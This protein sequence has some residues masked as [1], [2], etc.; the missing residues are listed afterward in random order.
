M[1][2]KIDDKVRIK[3]GIGKGLIGRITHTNI[4]ELAYFID[5]IAELN[6]WRAENSLELA[7]RKIEDGLEEGDIIVSEY[8]DSC[9]VLGVC[10]K[11]IFLSKDFDYDEAEDH[12]Y[13]LKW[14]IGQGYTLKDQEKETVKEEFIKISKKDIEGDF[15]LNKEEAL[16]W[17][18][19]GK[20][21][22]EAEEKI[23]KLK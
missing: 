17:V 8:G 4:A 13:T 20:I 18:K 16:K 1:K 19:I 6:G 14:L 22:S 23:K 15:D 2:F 3:K 21:I 7:N 11:A 5:G 10:G 12:I 9:E